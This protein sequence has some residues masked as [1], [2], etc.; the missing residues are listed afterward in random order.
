M[1]LGIEIECFLKC[2]QPFAIPN[3]WHRK[4]DSSLRRHN[5]SLVYIPV[6]LVSPVFNNTTEALNG[7]YRICNELKANQAASNKSCGLHIH[8]SGVG[9]IDI[10]E[11]GAILLKSRQNWK[12][13]A[14]YCGCWGTRK[15]KPVRKIVDYICHDHYE[16]RL[17]NGTIKYRAIQGYIRTLEQALKQLKPELVS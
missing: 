17:F 15:Y 7:I 14:G 4:S 9:E 12:S 16:V 8:F 11:L 6:E 1:K 2:I 3:N 13:R 5:L 10:R